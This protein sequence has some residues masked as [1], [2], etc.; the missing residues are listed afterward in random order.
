MV[1]RVWEQAVE[2]VGVDHAIVATDSDEI[3]DV[4]KAFG[5]NVCDC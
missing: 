5:A 2:A 4:A 3:A 1:Q